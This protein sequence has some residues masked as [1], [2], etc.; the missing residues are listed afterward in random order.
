M[1][2]VGDI[3]LCKCDKYGNYYKNLTKGRSY[4]IKSVID[5]DD[6]KIF[7]VIN[8]RGDVHGFTFVMYHIWFYTE[9]EMRKKK[10]EKLGCTSLIV[11]EE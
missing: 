3:L 2:K 4:E 9:I 6:I 8:N 11:T 5:I 10:L 1:L 7:E